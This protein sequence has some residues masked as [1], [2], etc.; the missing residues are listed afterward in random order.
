[1][2]VSYTAPSVTISGSPV[3]FQGKS[4]VFGSNVTQTAGAGDPL[5]YSWTLL[6]WQWNDITIPAA[7]TMQTFILP[8][9]A[10]ERDSRRAGTWVLRNEADGFG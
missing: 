6:K 5:T 4:L 1:L 9:K 8:T 3:D 2:T 10:T 7:S